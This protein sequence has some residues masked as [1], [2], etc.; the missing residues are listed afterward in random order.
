[1]PEICL[2]NS[3]SLNCDKQLK[4][5]TETEN[6]FLFIEIRI[7]QTDLFWFHLHGNFYFSWLWMRKGHDGGWHNLGTALLSGWSASSES[8]GVSVEVPSPGDIRK[9]INTDPE[10][11][12]G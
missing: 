5:Q 9:H 2:I 8:S 1:M 3:H 11:P 7:D 6:K 12:A 10:K 4:P